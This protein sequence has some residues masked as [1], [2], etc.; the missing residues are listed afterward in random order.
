M[1][2]TVVIIRIKDNN[3]ELTQILTPQAIRTHDPALAWPQTLIDHSYS[4]EE[5]D[6]GQ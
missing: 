4:I 3:K 5:A 2:G 1:W 6:K